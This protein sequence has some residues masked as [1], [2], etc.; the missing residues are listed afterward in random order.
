MELCKGVTGKAYYEYMPGFSSLRSVFAGSKLSAALLGVAA[1]GFAVTA[2]ASSE[3][4]DYIVMCDHDADTGQ[5]VGYLMLHVDLNVGG[6]TTASAATSAS[7][8]EIAGG[9]S[10]EPQVGPVGPVTAAIGKSIEPKVD[11]A[12]R[13]AE[14]VV[15]SAM[16]GEGNFDG[17]LQIVATRAEALNDFLPGLSKFLLARQTGDTEGFKQWTLTPKA[18]QV[19]AAKDAATGGT[20]VTYNR[21]VAELRVQIK[22][23]PD[24]RTVMAGLEGKND[25]DFQAAIDK[26]ILATD[27]QKNGGIDYG[28]FAVEVLTSLKDRKAPVP[29]TQRS[30]DAGI[31]NSA[32]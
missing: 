23:G 7:K 15:M 2:S 27:Q 10:I 30:M 20:V 28:S 18:L 12:G 26:V 14:Q 29:Y 8:A 1:L 19:R 6:S 11:T 5:E 9:K 31:T 21:V 25:S 4:W 32:Q 22:L 3:R 16:S 17:A 24:Y 13:Q